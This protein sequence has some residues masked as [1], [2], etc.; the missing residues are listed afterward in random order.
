MKRAITLALCIC[1]TIAPWALVFRV[2]AET[3]SI[4]AQVNAPGGGGSGGGGSVQTSIHFSGRA[5]PFSRVT[6][7][8]DGIVVGTTISGPDAKFSVS[9]GN[10]SSGNA[11]FGVFSED[12]RGIRSEVF[13]FPIV[14]TSGATI[15]ISGIFIAPTIDVDKSE[16]KQ[17]DT[18]TI[19]G[20]ST[21]ES[22]VIISIH[23]P[24]ELFSTVPT[25][26]S[27]AYLLAYD[28]S[29]LNLGIHETKSKTQ[30]ANEISPYGKVVSFV[31]GDESIAKSACSI[32]DL[33]CDGHVNLIDFSIMAFWYQK[34]GIP[35]KVDL[36]QDNAVNLVDFS[37]LAYYWTG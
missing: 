34:S 29:Q 3:L 15:D 11:T 31:V 33:N 36:N 22:S 19:F 1:L 6:I 7:L 8:K 26:A 18:I 17:G 35:T 16:V 25:D 37:I 13:S 30:L 9:I 20:Q 28:T 12:A 14:I 24:V 23:S 21:P 2:S 4:S 5:Y 32:A 27:G 10:L